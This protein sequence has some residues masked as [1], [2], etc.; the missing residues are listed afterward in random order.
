M[1]KRYPIPKNRQFNPRYI[2][3]F[4]ILESI[5]L[6]A[7]RL[8]LP[9][10]LEWIHDV[11]HVSML[12]KY[13]IDPS[14]MLEAP[15][16]ELKQDLSFDVQLG[17]IVDQKLKELRNKVIPMVKVLWKSNTIDEMTWDTETYMKS[18]YPTFSRISKYKF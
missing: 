3:P 11:F 17:G 2:G 6:V 15:P 9:Q 13:I 7:Y 1:E 18:R 5:G 16:V 14:H 4:K 8:E 10:D 12:R